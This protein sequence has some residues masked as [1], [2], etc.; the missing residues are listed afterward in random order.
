MATFRI[1][2]HVRLQEWVAEENGFFRE[3]GLD[4]EFE[5]QGY[6]GASWTTASVQPGR[7]RPTV[8]A[9]RRVGGH[10]EGAL[11]QRLGG[12]SLGRQRRRVG[13]AREDVGQGVLGLRLGHL[14][15]RPTRP[16]IGLRT[17]PT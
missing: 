7:R 6:A 17:S 8:R 16:T 9:Q 14:R 5:P 3:E 4:Y 13:D 1:Q 2:P 12:V 11:L 15:S 10:G